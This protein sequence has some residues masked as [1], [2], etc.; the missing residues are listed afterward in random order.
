MANLRNA[1]MRLVGSAS[2][3][4]LPHTPNNRSAEADPTQFAKT[5]LA[6]LAM[7]AVLACRVSAIEPTPLEGTEPLTLQGDIPAQLRAGINK[8][9]DRETAKS[10][11]ERAKL[12]HR[13]FSSPEAYEKSIAP[14]RE[15]LRKMIG[16]VDPRLPVTQM[17]F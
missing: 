2:A 10:V 12:W 9:V 4:R 6:S 5:I 8:F 17:E 15:H 14:N 16:A 11:T 13:D 3:D 1:L 7:A